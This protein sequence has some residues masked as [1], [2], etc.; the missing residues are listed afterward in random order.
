M[1][2]VGSGTYTFSMNAQAICESALRKTGAF[3]A[4]ETIPALDMTNVM[5]AL[6]AMCKDL[7]IDG[8]PLWCIQDIA[9]PTVVGQAAYNL[10]V[11]MG[12]PLPL[13]IL[14][15]YIRDLS[16]PNPEG[17][18]ND[19]QL[20]ITSR[21]DYDT[22]GQKFAQGIPN[23]IWYDPQLSGGILTLYD[24]PT[25][26]NHEIHVVAQRQIQDLNLATDNPDFPQEAA[27]MLIWGLLDEIAL[28]YRMP[29]D[30]RT[31]ANQKAVAF[32]NRFFDGPHVQEQAPI[33]FTPSERTF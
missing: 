31:E 24:V 4:Y 15:A 21:Y 13:R 12:M 10:S 3:D 8:G 14:D 18:G 26:A 25:D 30:E 28:E 1:A 20:V 2:I 7:A 17:G 33:M 5:Q 19:V 16:L 6:N 22:L 29:K 11:I 9:F 23:Q 32:K 27:R